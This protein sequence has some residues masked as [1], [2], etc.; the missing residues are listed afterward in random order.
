M[1]TYIIRTDAWLEV[2]A[3]NMDDALD[4]A[5]DAPMSAWELGE[6]VSIEKG[7]A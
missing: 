2:E 6:G 3:D 4:F 5:A 7:S 1:T